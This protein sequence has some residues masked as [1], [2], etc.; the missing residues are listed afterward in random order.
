[1]AISQI[2]RQPPQRPTNPTG[3][4]LPEDQDAFNKAIKLEEIGTGKHFT[5]GSEHTM[6]RKGLWGGLRKLKKRYRS[7]SANLSWKD[8]RKFHGVL[9]KEFK[10]MPTSQGTRG[11]SIKS[12]KRLKKKGR[13][14]YKSGEVSKADLKDF[15]KIV[16]VLGKKR[17]GP[18]GE[19]TRP[20]GPTQKNNGSNSRLNI[21]YSELEEMARAETNLPSS[22]SFDEVEGIEPNMHDFKQPDFEASPELLEKCDRA[23][24]EAKDL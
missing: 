22:S 18:T 6:R 9:S 13:Q 16:G 20:S 4:P 5:G 17:R 12:K 24:E 11:L 14:L 2:P 1:M 10:K 7:T 8:L 21:N 23:I 3:R 15:K 19:K